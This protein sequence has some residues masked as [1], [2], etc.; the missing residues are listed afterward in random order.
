MMRHQLFVGGDDGLT[1]EKRAFDPVVRGA[2]AADQFDHDFRVGGEHRV[3]RIGP[4]DG[5]GYPVH[6]LFVDAAVED[7]RQADVRHFAATENAG[8]RL[9]DGAKT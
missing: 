2:K 8:D 5:R 6:A 7:V 1:G 3:N 9:A 4:D